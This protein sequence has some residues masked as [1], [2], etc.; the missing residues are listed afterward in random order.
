MVGSWMLLAG[1]VV[2]P[3]FAGVVW[4][5]GR[6]ATHSVPVGASVLEDDLVAGVSWE[7]RLCSDDASAPVEG[8]VLPASAEPSEVQD[9]VWGAAA[10]TPLDVASMP[11]L[12]DDED[13]TEETLDYFFE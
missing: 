5:R 12:D 4:W 6:V 8:S 2:A 11:P 10:P 7:V 1:L 13:D 3:I 9:E